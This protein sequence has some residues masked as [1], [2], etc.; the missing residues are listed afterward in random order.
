MET[1]TIT[2]NQKLNNVVS[3]RYSTE[4]IEKLRAICD[5]LGLE[6]VSDLIKLQSLRF[7]YLEYV[8][9]QSNKKPIERRIKKND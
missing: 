7:D 5:K 6:K 1:E 8:N 9:E 2:T 3:I 4:Q